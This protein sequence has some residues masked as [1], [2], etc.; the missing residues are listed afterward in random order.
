MLSSTSFLLSEDIV[1]DCLP[2]GMSIHWVLL[3]PELFFRRKIQDLVHLFDTS[4]NLQ[5]KKKKKII[6]ICCYRWLLWVT[7]VLQGLDLLSLCRCG[8][9]CR[10]VLLLQVIVLDLE[11][12]HI[13]P[14][15]NSR[16][17]GSSPE[18]KKL[19]AKISIPDEHLSHCSVFVGFF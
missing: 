13:Y 8:V 18:G 19:K 16:S 5:H 1:V 3:P 17:L 10:V 11:Q 14:L 4:R 6:K 9:L 12:K 2:D 15:T 7:C